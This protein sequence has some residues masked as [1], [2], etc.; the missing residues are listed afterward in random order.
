[1]NRLGMVRKSRGRC[2]LAGVRR[3][4]LALLLSSSL[5]SSVQAQP[6]L[7][8]SPV[9]KT[10]MN[11][12][13]I[14]L[15]IVIDPRV[16][17]EIQ[18]VQLYVKTTPESPWTLQ[19]KAPATQKEFLYQALRDGEYWFTV[20][21]VDRR[22]RSSV[23]NLA[24]QPPG[25]IVVLDRQPPQVQLRRL[26]ATPVG[27]RIECKVTDEHPNPEQ[28]RFEYQ[29]Q[30]RVW[31]PLE[32]QA[33]QPDVYC[34]PRQALLTGMIRVLVMDRCHNVWQ[35]ELH[36]QDCPDS[37]TL[38]PNAMVARA[39][40]ELP[41]V[42]TTEPGPAL[43]ADVKPAK[44][45]KT[46]VEQGPS[47]HNHTLENVPGQ[48]PQLPVTGGVASV[49]QTV[50]R[51][52]AAPTTESACKIVR[53][54][55]LVL[56]YRIEE[57][58]QSGVGKIEIYITRDQGQTWQWLTEDVDKKSP[59]EVTLPG[60]GLYGIC[61]VATNGRGFGGE[62]PRQGQSPDWLV[63]VDGTPPT[64]KILSVE[65]FK[66]NQPG[67][68]MVS[69]TAQDRNLKDTPICL[70]YSASVTGPWRPI[71][72]GLRN[73]GYYPWLVPTDAGGNVYVRLTVEDRAGHVTEARSEQ[74]QVDDMS[75]PRVRV[76]GIE[77][78]PA[79]DT[80]VN[81]SSR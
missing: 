11:K 49:E 12:S 60:D 73:T 35:R 20:A 56:N 37:H 70:Y 24:Q 59:V 41:K 52:I 21:T 54:P 79:P 64:A 27:Q 81:G 5:A 40:A 10:Y 1:M 3:L 43:P 44:F 16:Q 33:D 69:W 45:E 63:E 22:G 72:E 13:V 7:T 47:L 38:P 32:A 65:P 55:H 2:L 62:P 39:P 26:D 4:G 8:Q 46:V 18:E 78:E 25:A 6:A 9:S 29:T 80:L 51:K 14:V 68:M 77:S 76:T 17:G 50:A 66:G 30:D 48:L 58:G 28:T 15:P 23:A 71:A 67:L 53:D 31:R 57:L 34:I 61:L 36:V 74:L 75:R 19:E 42:Q